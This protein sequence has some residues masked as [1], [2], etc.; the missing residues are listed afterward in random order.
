MKQEP[1]F[2]GIKQ[3]FGTASQRTSTCQFHFSQCLKRLLNKFP[4]EL[5]DLKDEFQVLMMPAPLSHNTAGI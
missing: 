1:I 2:N 5:I 3:V 4:G